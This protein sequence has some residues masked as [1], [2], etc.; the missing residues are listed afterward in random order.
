MAYAPLPG[1]R[2]RYQMSGTRG[3][4][5]LVLSNSLG[6]DLE[7]WEP[8]LKALGADHC[9][10]RYDTRGHGESASP[11][12]PYTIEMLGRDVLALLDHVESTQASFCGISM[13]GLTGMWL[14]IN[15]P[16]RITKLVLANTGAKIG[17]P[18]IW[19]ARIAQVAKGGVASI[20]DAVLDRWFTPEFKAAHPAAVAKAK[21]MMDRQ[22]TDGYNALCAA[23][24]DADLR[25]A[26]DAIAA[27]TLVIVGAHDVP[28]PPASGEFIAKAIRGARLVT[29]PA[30]HISNIEAADA[31]TA[32]VSEFLKN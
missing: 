10:V 1:S 16:E 28:T 15:A 26:I 22:P 23:V 25:E 9:V 32:A 20:S 8:Q 27:P 14:A 7:M 24:R 18:E 19:N 17:S 3:K 31:F 4:P 21:V 11:P 13:G 2:L 30:A 5:T 29:L 12:G 6:A